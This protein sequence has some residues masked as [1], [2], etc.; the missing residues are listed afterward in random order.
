MALRLVNTAPGDVTDP[1]KPG[2]AAHMGLKS[3]SLSVQIATLNVDMAF[4]SAIHNSLLPENDLGLSKIGVTTAFETS[5][6]RRVIASNATRS[7]SSGSLV[8]TK[9][10]NGLDEAG[11]YEL[12]LPVANTNSLLGYFKFR[13]KSAW[14]QHNPDWCNLTNMVGMYFGVEHGGL[15]TA[16]YAFL[17]NNGSGGSIVFGGPLQSLSTARPGQ[18]ELATDLDPLTVGNQGWMGLADNSVLELFIRINLY[19]SP[20]RAELWTRVAGVGAPIYQGSIQISVLGTFPTGYYTNARTGPSSTATLFFGNIGR[21]GDILQLDDWALYPDYRAAIVNG[22]PTANHSILIYPDGPVHYSSDAAIFPTA[23]P[24]ARWFNATGIG[25]LTPAPEF[26]YD[27]GRYSTPRYLSLPKEATGSMAYTRVE[28]RLEERQDGSMMEVYMS[29]A[30]TLKDGELVGPGFAIEDGAQSYKVVMLETALQKNYGIASDDLAYDMAG[31]FYQPSYE[32]DWS[33]PRLVRLTVDRRRSKVLLHLDEN[34]VVDAPIL[35]HAQIDSGIQTFPTT[36]L[37]GTTLS[38][39]VTTNAG[40]SWAT[41]SHVFGSQVADIDA[42][43]TLLNGDAAFVGTG[44][45]AFTVLNRGT[46]FSFRMNNA[47]PLYGIR[48]Q[49]GSTALGVGKLTMTAPGETFGA[50]S[51]FPVAPDTVG[52]FLVG[53]PYASTNQAELRFSHV[54]YLPRYLAWEAEDSLKPDDT[55]VDSG[56]RF[57]KSAVGGG[58]EGIS[59]FGITIVKSGFTSGTEYRYYKRTQAFD[60]VG[61][62]QVDFAANLVEF[63]NENGQISAANTAI[64]AGLVIFLGDKRVYLNFFDCGAFGKKLGII[65]GSGTPQDI[66]SQTALG[67]SFSTAADWTGYNTFRVVVRSFESIQVWVGDVTKAPAITIPWRNTVDGFDLPLDITSPA[68]AF[69]HFNF[70]SN[71]SSS[72]T[73]WRYVRWGYSNGYD[74]AVSQQYPDGHPKYLFGG[75]E[76]LL[77]AFDES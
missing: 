53:H 2:Q 19:A 17:R 47:G 28:P 29:G 68:I 44:A 37:S 71:P 10:T 52:R 20:Q 31:T 50:Q 9:T 41:R 34:K 64:D 24:V 7:L 13:K 54:S 42:F 49:P 62:V 11:I 30:S 77:S 46:T 4:S 32:V 3:E 14:V 16:A 22:L 48:V 43:T 69:G 33:V 40:S 70:L 51:V 18:I 56:V 55:T 59:P 73:N 45:S 65:P 15:N 67:K 58:G 74:V 23:L 5:E 21:T 26:F 66:L 6:R 63:T 25:S 60:N 61:S 57:T 75:R 36:T 27:P 12:K 39:D 38:V 35:S 76:F 8:I 72:T 1:V